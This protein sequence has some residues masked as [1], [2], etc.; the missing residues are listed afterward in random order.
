MSLSQ[1]L[2]Y[3]SSSTSLLLSR[4]PL[5]HYLSRRPQI[6]CRFKKVTSEPLEHRDFVDPQGSPWISPY[7]TCECTDNVRK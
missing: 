1:L 4:S 6:L 5:Q 3:I 2:N 7:Q